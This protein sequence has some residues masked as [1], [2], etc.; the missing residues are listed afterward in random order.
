MTAPETTH[1]ARRRT[2]LRTTST[3][4][5]HGASVQRPDYLILGGGCFAAPSA[6]SLVGLCLDVEGDAGRRIPTATS[7]RFQRVISH[8]GQPRVERG[9]AAWGRTV[10]GDHR[11]ADRRPPCHRRQSRRYG[12]GPM[13]TDLPPPERGRR[14]FRLMQCAVTSA[15]WPVQVGRRQPGLRRTMLALG[16]H[17]PTYPRRRLRATCPGWSCSR[18]TALG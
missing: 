1:N 2:T 16:R 7:S 6:R 15:K 4:A 13:P 14:I 17:R 9:P 5:P 11:S 18:M 12:D 3:N 8:P 10:N